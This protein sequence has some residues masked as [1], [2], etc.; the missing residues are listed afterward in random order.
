M[1]RDA[2]KLGMMI[3]SC[4]V[5]AAIIE[6]LIILSVMTVQAVRTLF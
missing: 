5:V 4:I 3:G 1:N 6:L 2:E